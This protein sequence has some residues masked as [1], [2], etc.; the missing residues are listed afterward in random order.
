MWLIPLQSHA[1]TH[2]HPWDKLSWCLY[3]THSLNILKEILKFQNWKLTLWKCQIASEA[4]TKTEPQLFK[5]HCFLQFTS[6]FNFFTIYFC[7]YNTF[8]ALRHSLSPCS[9][10]WVLIFPQGKA[11]LQELSLSRARMLLKLPNYG[12]Y[13][14][15][16]FLHARITKHFNKQFQLIKKKGEI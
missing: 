13:Y 9:H 11:H 1:F 15:Y 3:R 14:F 16:S 2:I 6:F 4:L 8:A 12:H 10:H 7:T 5:I